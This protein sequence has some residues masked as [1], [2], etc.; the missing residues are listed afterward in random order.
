MSESKIIKSTN[1]FTGRGSSCISGA[2]GIRD[3]KVIAV[4]QTSDVEALLGDDRPEIL[5]FEDAFITPGF[6]DSHLHFFHSA[7]Y[8][9]ALARRFVG[10]SEADCVRR[11]QEFALEK[12]DGWLL[13]Q[14]WRE[15]LWDIPIMPSK[16]SLDEAFSD[17]P[18]ALYSGDAHTLWLNSVALR[19]LGV[20]ED[21]IAPAGGEYCKDED[22]HLTG[23]VRESAAMECMAKIV[24]TFS[25]AEI[26][27]AYRGFLKTLAQNGI[28]SVCDMSLMAM[29]GMDFI[30]DDIYTQLLSQGEL[31]A[32]V[33][34]Y[35]T[36]LQNKSRFSAMREKFDSDDI[37][38]YL[39]V[40]GFKQFYDGVSSQHT[41]WLTEDY[42]NARFAG[43]RGKPTITEDEMRE[44]VFSAQKMGEQVRIHT[45]GDRAIHSALDIFDE[46]TK[47]F[48]RLRSGKRHALEHVENFLPEDIERMDELSIIASIQPPHITLDPGGP[49]RD[50]GSE[51]VKYMWPI[52]TLLGTLAI[53]SFGTDSPV[54][55]VNS[56][57]VLYTAVTR[58]DPAE[59][60]PEGGWLP[61]EKIDVASAIRCYTNGSAW[62]CG[63]SHELGLL[64]CGMYA[65]IAVLDTNLLECET[66]EILQAK[67]VATFLGGRQV[68]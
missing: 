50:L 17:R 5:D 20:T 66:D 56:M 7:L 36:L 35:P 57:N 49:E 44:L 47:K 61:Q 68:L 54:V 3:G 13:A 18:V 22:G 24:N 1:I 26:A 52:R 40:S 10:V 62:S 8:R 42:T 30:R 41:A 23:I 2:L 34:M 46:A 9:S 6:H 27:Q 48:G 32:R 15:Y 64:E 53:V 67:V 45:I 59:H 14:G 55:D 21:T 4:G 33:H 63:R 65:D 11:M 12:R 38:P 39:Q 25:D 31:S 58:S 29:E 60:K 16:K 19:E 51:R 37:R 43:D 28:T